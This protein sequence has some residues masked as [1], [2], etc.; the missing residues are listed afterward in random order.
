VAVITP[1]VDHDLGPDLLA[2]LAKRKVLSV[3]PFAAVLALFGAETLDPAL[4]RSEEDRWIVDELIAIAPLGG[5]RHRRPPTGFLDSDL[6]WQVWHEHHFAGLTVPP[7][8]IAVHTATAN[9]VV[10]QAVEDLAPPVRARLATRWANGAAPCDVILDVVAAG[11]AGDVSALGAVAGVLWAPTDDAALAQQ[12]LLARVRLEP[13]LGKDR[14]TASS[15]AAWADAAGASITIDAAAHLDRAQ[16]ILTDVSA[17]DLAILSDVLPAGFEQRLIALARALSAGDLKAAELALT[18][19]GR[20]RN[21]ALRPRRLTTATAAVR[22]LRRGTLPPVG[23]GFAEVVRAYATDGA[24][25][26]D[27][28]RL[29]AD[30]DQSTEVAANYRALCQRLDDERTAGDRRFAEALADWSEHEPAPRSP[31]VVLVERILDEV[32][33]VAARA[34]PVLLVVCDGMSLAIANEL[35]R[36]IYGEGWVGVVPDDRDHWLTGVAMLPTVTEIS[37][38]SL[39]A[40]NRIEGGRNEERDGFAAHAALR[41]ASPATRR[42]VLYHKGQLVGPN[43]W[44]LAEKVQVD[45]ADPDQRVVG[46]VVN[47]V[48]DH[49]NRGQQV[50]VDWNLDTLRP[51][52]ALLDAAVDAGRIVV[53]TAD[54][55]HVIHGEGAVSRPVG[56]GQ[57]ERWRTA[58]PAPQADELEFHGPRVLKGGRVVLPTD[59]RIRY[60]GHKHGYHG[61]ATPQEVLVPVAVIARSAPSGWRAVPP[62]EPAWWSGEAAAVT[63]MSPVRTAEPKPPKSGQLSMLEPESTPATIGAVGWVGAFVASPA[64][65]AQSQR[66]RLPRPMPAERV[67]RYIGAIDANGGSIPLP[68]LATRLAEPADQLR[69]ALALVQRLVNLDGAEILAIRADQSVELNR[70]LLVLQFDVKA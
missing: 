11:R 55:G 33:A 4:A 59:D 38:A 52:G 13:V 60:G 10:A 23:G 53:I 22:A 34:A 18:W 20:H 16:Q 29:L 15:A 14:L 50:Q 30:G 51:L 65:V 32:V 8:L 12:Q 54:H 56:A 48:D 1:C 2:R 6:A 63:P 9:P 39:L 66:I 49:L 40:G 46:V 57:G 7:D 70:D 69:M 64:F 19:L 41:A 26:D 21:R 24:W 5:W 43:G 62:H 42:P 44:A 25:V 31:A 61:G 37:R 67:A 68:A 36:A 27:A 17:N 58:P 45:L 3:D 35:L 47:A 28:R